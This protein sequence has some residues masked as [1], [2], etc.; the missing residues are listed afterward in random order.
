[1]SKKILRC[2]DYFLESVTSLDSCPR[3]WV[4]LDSERYITHEGEVKF[5]KRYIKRVARPDS[6]KR[7]RDVLE[8]R[9]LG[10]FADEPFVTFCTVTYMG[11]PDDDFCLHSRRNFV[12]LLRLRGFRVI[13]VDEYQKRGV[14]HH[15]FLTNAPLDEIPQWPLGLYSYSP[16]QT[17]NIRKI[18][19]Y[20]TKYLTKDLDGEFRQIP[21]GRHLY[22]FTRNCPS[23]SH[24]EDI[25]LDVK[26]IDKVNAFSTVKIGDTVSRFDYSRCMYKFLGE[27]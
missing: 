1:V 15:H 11:E 26:I 13:G 5:Y 8:L 3:N 21:A 19:L 6:I 2:G 17:E 27:I 9:L 7:S 25:P 14:L 24:I 16:V 20:L 22:F 12:R 18:N 4:H 23:V 10:A